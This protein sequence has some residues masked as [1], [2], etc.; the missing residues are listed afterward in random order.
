MMAVA[1]LGASIIFSQ[2]LNKHGNLLI[3]INIVSPNCNGVTLSK[4]ARG[5]TTRQHDQGHR[6]R[7]CPR[8]GELTNL[9][10]PFGRTETSALKI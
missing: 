10:E 5:L 8:D 6:W 1:R 2:Y 7:T 3:I 9:L 4:V